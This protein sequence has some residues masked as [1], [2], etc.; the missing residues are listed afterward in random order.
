[1]CPR[2]TYFLL[3]Y[4]FSR[5]D[6]ESQT[7]INSDSIATATSLARFALLAAMSPR[8]T[9][10]LSRHGDSP[11]RWLL[12]N[13]RYHFFRLLGLERFKVFTHSEIN[14]RP[15]T[16]PYDPLWPTKRLSSW[17]LEPSVSKLSTPAIY[18]RFEPMNFILR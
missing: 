10:G 15:A 2:V 5:S 16:V 6:S 3:I 12:W 11:K 7:E 18:Q 14:P 1:M 4:K 8:L 9:S 13:G 17:R